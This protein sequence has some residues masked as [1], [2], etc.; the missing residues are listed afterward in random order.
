[1]KFK[2]DWDQVVLQ[3]IPAKNELGCTH[4]LS[5]THTAP[6][7][8]FWKPLTLPSFRILKNQ[9]GIQPRKAV[10]SAIVR[11]I[12]LLRLRNV[13]KEKSVP[14]FFIFYVHIYYLQPLFLLKHWCTKQGSKHHMHLPI[15]YVLPSKFSKNVIKFYFVLWQEEKIRKY[16]SEESK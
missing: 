14:T 4:F 16:M 13:V 15:C 5:H 8:Y 11:C 7:C 1:M 10:L 9:G 12:P 2:E 6:K 3:C